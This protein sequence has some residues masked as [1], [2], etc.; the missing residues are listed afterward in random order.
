MNARLPRLVPLLV[1]AVALAV[2]LAPWGEVFGSGS[3]RLLGDS[4]P[5]YHVLRAERWLRG[6]PGAPWRDPALAWPS[7]ADVPWPPLFDGL[8]AAASRVVDGDVVERDRLVRL[9]A[10]LPVA[11]G[12]A[13][14]ALTV[15]L[16]R[17]A[18]GGRGGWVAGLVV[19][20][21]SAGADHSRLGRAD[22]HVVELLTF[23][24][25]LLAL[26][27][28]AGVRR[29]GPAWAIALLVPVAFWTWMGSALHLLALA[30]VATA[31]HLVSGPREEDDQARRALGALAG[32]LL[33]GA[34][35]IAG[36]VAVLG[37]AGALTSGRTTGI[38]ML[39]VAMTAAAGTYAAL[40]GAL[41]RLRPGPPPVGVAQV[42]LAAAVPAAAL[43]L[44][45]SLRHGV[46]GGL[47]ALTAGNAWYAGI[48]E[49]QPLVNV[50]TE[51][52]ANELVGV[53]RG[54][55]LTLVVAPLAWPAVRRAWRSEPERRPALAA[56]VVVGLLLVAAALARRRFAPYAILPLAI[57][58]ELA[59]REGVARLGR[60]WPALASRGRAAAL[61]TAT[62]L[63]VVAPSVPE[64]LATDPV[65]APAEEALLRW[66]GGRPTAPLREAVFAPWTLGHVIQ[67]FAGRP[68]LTSPFGT[69]GGRGAMEA[70][71]AVWFAPDQAMAEAIL[72]RRRCGYVLLGYV[73]PESMVLHGF[74]PPGTPA[75][76]AVAEDVISGG[77][78]LETEAFWR[79]VPVRLYYDDGRA[80]GAQ[81]ALDGFRLLAET[82]RTSPQNAALEEQWKLFEPVPGARLAVTAAAGATVRAAIEAVSNAGRRFEFATEAIAGA[83]GVAV[84]RLPY[85]SGENGAVR[86]GPWRVSDGARAVPLVVHEQDVVRGGRVAL[87]L[88]PRASPS[89]DALS[90]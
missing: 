52:L 49:F 58:T 69:E 83:D 10:L 3:P 50:G 85:A 16:A 45:P 19:A 28:A 26:V 39:H 86:T 66:L 74:A 33:A 71:A 12:L 13:V 88:S 47:V 64:H 30:A 35:L 60:R 59:V 53:A 77:K 82:P 48:G 76:V 5:Y 68:V 73:P 84:L 46:A 55:G 42:A 61:V 40:L 80:L 17:R 6:A 54:M 1:I 36:S 11:L 87:D 25:L 15:A 78:L 70:A 2:R 81:A 7:G 14:L 72:A 31:L 21:T 90:R 79:L 27:A 67:Y 20:A 63:A 24:A 75:P 37:P 34:A 38:G 41:R 51:R 65:I 56:V 89:A 18:L 9:A 43:L 62:S 8:L 57:A 44:V 4:D 32:G 23:V 22:Q 29:T